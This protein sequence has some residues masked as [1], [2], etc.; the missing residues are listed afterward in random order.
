M[1]LEVKCFATVIEAGSHPD[2][3]PFDSK[4]N[5]GHIEI[6]STL[7]ELFPRDFISIIFHQEKE[8]LSYTTAVMAG[9]DS[10]KKMLV[11]SNPIFTTYAAQAKNEYPVPLTNQPTSSKNNSLDK[12][13]SSRF[14]AYKNYFFVTNRHYSKAELN[15]VKLRIHYEVKKFDDE[16]NLMAEEL[17]SI[18]INSKN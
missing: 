13:V 2:S 1:S 16:L 9:E 15:Q 5:D 12:F 3:M 8:S 4:K 10:D 17:R 6:H 11:L 14:W 7:Y 18:G